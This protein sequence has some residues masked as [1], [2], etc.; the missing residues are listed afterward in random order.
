MAQV[1]L[2]NRNKTVI[3]VGDYVKAHPQYANSVIRTDYQDTELIGI[4][5]E[6]IL[7]GRRGLINL[8][9][10][11]TA[12]SQ[13]TEDSTHRLV[14]DAEK[15]TWNAKTDESFVIAMAISL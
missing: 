14:T 11:T 12:L 13:L 6:F 9:E 8:L 4:S 2:F 5:A 15:A 1:H 3:Q 10:G 7:P